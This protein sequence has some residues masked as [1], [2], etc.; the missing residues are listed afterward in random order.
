MDF[1]LRKIRNLSL[2]LANE[3][4]K[5]CIYEMIKNK[6]MFSLNIL[7]WIQETVLHCEKDETQK[8]TPNTFC[9]SFIPLTSEINGRFDT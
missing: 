1:F 9:A 3:L 2:F 7:W 5:G 4:Y 6:Q 8:K